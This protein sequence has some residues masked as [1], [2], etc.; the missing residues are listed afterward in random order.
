MCYVSSKWSLLWVLP[1]GTPIWEAVYISSKT[2]AQANT[3]IKITYAIPTPPLWHKKPICLPSPGHVI[4]LFFLLL[5]PFRYPHYQNP[6]IYEEQTKTRRVSSFLED[7]TS[8]RLVCEKQP[9][10]SQWIFLEYFLSSCW[11][12]L[13]NNRK[14]I[15]EEKLQL[16][17]QQKELI[18]RHCAL[19]FFHFICLG[20]VEVFIFC[21][22]DK[23]LW[24]IH[25]RN[26]IHTHTYLYI[27]NYVS[28]SI[29]IHPYQQAGSHT[30]MDDVSYFG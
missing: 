30:T 1:L 22:S 19:L 20:F 2:F 4:S 17:P 9:G 13:G 21:R 10:T 7:V 11:F 15:W 26:F 18:M 3:T 5:F 27:Y 23:L 6:L 8:V 24:K 12:F 29:F 28:V 25:T 16:L 14:E